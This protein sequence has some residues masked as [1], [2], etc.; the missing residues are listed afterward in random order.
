MFAI[1]SAPAASGPTDASHNAAQASAQQQ[2]LLLKARMKGIGRS[3]RIGDALIIELNDEN[4]N[5]LTPPLP[6]RPKVPLSEADYGGGTSAAESD[7]SV[8]PAP[9]PWDVEGWVGFDISDDDTA[10]A[11]S[12]VV[13]KASTTSATKSRSST[14]VETKTESFD[15]GHT[16][17]SEP[18]NFDQDPVQEY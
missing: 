9:V 5:R 7:S 2:Q 1:L 15:S 8:D 4:K 17:L 3:M 14:M 18:V 6:L 10:A 16:T 12:S 13:K 11:A